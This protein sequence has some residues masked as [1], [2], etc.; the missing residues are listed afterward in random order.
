MLTHH[1][2]FL[3]WYEG[4]ES[5]AMAI[6][7]ERHGI[8]P[9]LKAF[10][11]GGKPIWGTCAGMIL[12]SNRAIMQKA[13]GQPL[14]GGL[15]VEVCRNFFGSQVGRRQDTSDAKESSCQSL[16]CPTITRRYPALRSCC[17]WKGLR[18]LVASGRAVPCRQSLSGL[19]PS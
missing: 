14:I 6:V 2:P 11:Q 4:G 3:L 16:P 7:G 8:F 18:R 15:D 5:T 13:G 19:P 12:L 17:S 9:K 10:V 1:V